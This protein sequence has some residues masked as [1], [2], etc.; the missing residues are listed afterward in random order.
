MTISTRVASVA[1]ARIEVSGWLWA[2]CSLA[3]LAVLDWL[4]V[5][6]PV[7][8]ASVDSV[9]AVWKRFLEEAAAGR[10]WE[11]PLDLWMVTGLNF[12]AAGAIGWLSAAMLAVAATAIRA[13]RDD[14]SQ[15]ADVQP[16]AHLASVRS[17]V[18]VLSMACSG[19]LMAC[20]WALNTL[21]R[22]GTSA[23]AVLFAVVFPVC[24]VLLRTGARRLY[25]GDW[26]PRWGECAILLVYLVAT[27]GVLA[28]EWRREREGRETLAEIW[29][30]VEEMPDGTSTACVD[31]MTQKWSESERQIEGAT[32]AQIR[33]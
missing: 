14:G 18:W 10:F 25:G 12:C 22:Y 27:L 6:W 23:G 1:R 31:G 11:D 30:V 29:R 17:L 8:P 28:G 5:K 13:C 24:Y 2:A 4:A 21:H 32:G 15:V 7:I 9:S 16:G 33:P 20:M 3:S 26:K 19:S